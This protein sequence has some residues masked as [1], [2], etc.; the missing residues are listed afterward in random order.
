MR[1]IR[2]ES[3]GMCFGVRDALALMQSVANP[4]DVTVLGE[5]VHNPVVNAQLTVRGFQ[6]SSTLAAPHTPV[7]MITAHGVSN[8]VRH[9]LAAAGKQILD[10]TCP[11]VRKAHAAALELAAENRFV[12]V[13]GKPDHVEVRGLTGDLPDDRFAILPAADAVRP[14]PHSR[15]GIL[16]QTTTPAADFAAI[17]QR[18]RTLNP[19]ADIRVANTVCAPTRDRQT[20]LLR[21]LDTHAP[22]VLVVVG[23]RNSNNT[24]RLAD[25]ARSRGIRALHVEGPADL[26]PAAFAGCTTVGV[27]AGTSTLDETINA[28]IRR[29]ED[30]GDACE[31]TSPRA[32]A[33]IR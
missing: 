29:L 18:V 2:A 28:V 26:D 8:R 19:G 11:L 10:T 17:V 30:F 5:L 16:A 15:L 25:T 7:A 24:R 22:D 31:C 12:L 13:V 21:L 23:G 6:L 33:S 27:T 9:Q 3:M 32:S 14:Y 20:A 1:V 4:A